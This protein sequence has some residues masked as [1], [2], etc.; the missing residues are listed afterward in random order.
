M[1]VQYIRIRKI[2]KKP[3]DYDCQ[4]EGLLGPDASFADSTIPNTTPRPTSCPVQRVVRDEHT[5]RG[6]P[7]ETIVTTSHDDV[8][9][10]AVLAKRAN[11]GRL[12]RPVI[13]DKALDVL[14][15]Q[16]VGI[17]IQ[18]RQQSLEDM[19]QLV[20]RSYPFRDLE[21]NELERVILQL[22]ELRLIRRF[23][24]G[25]SPRSPRALQ[26]YFEN[27]S[28]IADVKRYTV[29]DFFRKRRIG[30]LDQDFVARRCAPGAEFIL[31]GQT[32]KVISVD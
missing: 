12:E 31:R 22:E 24:S 8:V 19:L 15:H 30:S 7:R 11:E 27:L 5:Q 29:F 20:K 6:N 9:E 3:S 2:R 23:G 18:K 21:P 32:W 4:H 25:Y 17:L 1:S 10:S 13:H 26:Y 14:A 28:V 16:I